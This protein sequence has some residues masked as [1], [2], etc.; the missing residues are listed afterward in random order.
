MEGSPVTALPIVAAKGKV[1]G[2]PLCI[3]TY[4]LLDNGYNSTFC[5]ARLM[6]HLV[7]IGKKTRV[8]LTT[9]DSNKDVD[10]A[11]ANNLMVSDLD[12]NV[13]IFLPEVLDQLR[14]QVGTS[15]IDGKESTFRC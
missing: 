2:S 13:A 14:L 1:K 11:L 10:T 6:E 7:V 8:K 15:G 12:K 4:A 9:M 5:S 3:E